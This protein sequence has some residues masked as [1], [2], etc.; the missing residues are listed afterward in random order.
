MLIKDAF[1]ILQIEWLSFINI[2]KFITD[3]TL[4]HTNKNHK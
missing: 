2:T 4:L 3:Q 1:N